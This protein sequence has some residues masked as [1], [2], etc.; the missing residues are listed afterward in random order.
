MSEYVVFFFISWLL[1][2]VAVFQHGF[3]RAAVLKS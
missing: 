1:I 2:N 3:S